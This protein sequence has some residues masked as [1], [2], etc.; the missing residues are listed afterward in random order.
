[1]ILQQWYS[2]IVV[3]LVVQTAGTADKAAVLTI[4]VSVV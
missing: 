2:G 4:F 1:M 3:Y